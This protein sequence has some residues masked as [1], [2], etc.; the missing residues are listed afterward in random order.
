MMT[1]GRQK[2]KT[3][4]CRSL[5][6]DDNIFHCHNDSDGFFRVTRMESSSWLILVLS[7]FLLWFFKKRKKDEFS[8]EVQG[9]AHEKSRLGNIHFFFTKPEP[10]KFQKLY[11][12]FSNE[13]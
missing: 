11:D 12:K 5:A 9:I 1:C 7:F 6:R 3:E 8:L 10:D 13:K 4:N 2:G